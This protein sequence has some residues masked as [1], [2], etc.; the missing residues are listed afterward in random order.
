MRIVKFE[1]M[2]FAKGLAFLIAHLSYVLCDVK[3]NMHVSR[4]HCSSDV[5]FS[6]FEHPKGSA[7]HGICIAT[8]VQAGPM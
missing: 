1:K 3:E 4:D 2:F 7:R 6:D 5:N 8:L